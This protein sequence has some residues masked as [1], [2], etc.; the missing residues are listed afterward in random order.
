M[1]TT[2][3]AAFRFISMFDDFK[4]AD[5]CHCNNLYLRSLYLLQL[6]THLHDVMLD[7]LPVMAALRQYLEQLS[8]MDPPPIKRDLILEQA[9]FRGFMAELS[10]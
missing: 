9:G 10:R 3:I 5:A 7:Q 2:C 1:Q 8:I 4:S 6:R